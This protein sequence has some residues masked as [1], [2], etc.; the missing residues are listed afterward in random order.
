MRPARCPDR[1][2][3]DDEKACTK[4]GRCLYATP[5][6]EAEYQRAVAAERAAIEARIEERCQPAL[7][8]IGWLIISP[9]GNLLLLFILV[10]LVCAGARG[11]AELADLMV[12]SK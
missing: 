10:F 5:Q 12:A 1:G 2:W 9:T 3:C 11:L 4:A 7:R 8:F 6:A